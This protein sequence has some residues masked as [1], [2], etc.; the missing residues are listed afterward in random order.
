MTTIEANNKNHTQFNFSYNHDLP[1][2]KSI[3]P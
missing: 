1:Y 3:R 2:K